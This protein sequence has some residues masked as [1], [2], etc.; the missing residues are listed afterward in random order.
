M[1]HS[2]SVFTINAMLGA[3]ASGSVPRVI[4]TSMDRQV[5]MWDVTGQSRVWT[6]AGLGGF[7]YQISQSEHHSSLVSPMYLFFQGL[8]F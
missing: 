1:Q 3:R 4:T 6:V 7:V 5:S 2:R 8:G